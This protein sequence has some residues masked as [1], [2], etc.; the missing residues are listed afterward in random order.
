[1]GMVVE[2]VDVSADTIKIGGDSVENRSLVRIER[3]FAKNISQLWDGGTTVA[4]GGCTTGAAGARGGAGGGRSSGTSS[5]R[6]TISGSATH[7]SRAT[8]TRL[9]GNWGGDLSDKE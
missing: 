5:G 4:G 6:G 7:A 2:P 1:M 8:G 9:V 3:M